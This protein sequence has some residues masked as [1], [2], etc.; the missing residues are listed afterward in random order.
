M[1]Q[2]AGKWVA[3]FAPSFRS[4][5]F[6]WVNFTHMHLRTHVKPA[7]RGQARDYVGQFLTTFKDYPQRLLTR[8]ASEGV[9]FH[10]LGI[11]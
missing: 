11:G 6:V 3:L 8:S 5:F 10:V 9:L 7:S 2:F 1:L 4:L